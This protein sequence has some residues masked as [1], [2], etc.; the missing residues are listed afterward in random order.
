MS[1]FFLTHVEPYHPLK[2]KEARFFVREQ[3]LE[4]KVS[5]SHVVIQET[6]HYFL[7]TNLFP[8]DV[9]PFLMQ[10]LN[11]EEIRNSSLHF[12]LKEYNRNRQFIRAE[13]SKEE[14]RILPPPFRC[15]GTEGEKQDP[16]GLNSPSKLLQWFY[17]PGMCL[18]SL[19]DIPL[20][21][22]TA[23]YRKKYGYIGLEQL[24]TN[25]Y[26]VLDIETEGW[27]QG[28][29]SIFMVVYVSP[30]RKII[31]HNFNFPE[32]SEQEQDGFSLIQF[33]TQLEL[34]EKL[35]ALLHEED[36]LWLFGHNIMKF[37]Q[38]KLRD[39]TKAYAPAVNRY[40]PIYKSV[41]GLGRVLTK[42]RFTLDSYLYH[43]NHRNYHADNKLETVSEDFEKSINYKEQA[44]LVIAARAGDTGA[45]QRLVGYCIGDGLA[46]EKK[47]LELQGITA[48]KAYYFRTSPDRI[49]AASRSTLSRSY[50]RRRHFLVKDT[51]EDSWKGWY[52]Q[53]ESFSLD[54]LKLKFIEKKFQRGFF[55]KA[56]IVYLTPFIA[57]ATGLGKR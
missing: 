28:K 36:P 13:G 44:E 26:A 35:P 49:C 14:Q 43:S 45:F 52:Q 31:L 30:Q 19:K 39:I 33:G 3:D 32:L 46:T 12:E 29:D 48:Q 24:L 21:L 22:E 7:T 38:I 2:G 51:F 1:L 16:C 37:D 6:P 20:P 50:W 10:L 40:H 15:R 27:E 56:Q 8:E 57:A 42:G 47:G 34:G 41:Q 11:D 55:P 4:K 5:R 18:N 25:N 54:Q 53:E 23:A 9:S 17:P